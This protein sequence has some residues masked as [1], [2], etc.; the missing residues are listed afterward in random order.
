[1]KVAG[2]RGFLKEREKKIAN[3]PSKT[4][5]GIP[6]E[7]EAQQFSLLSISAL[8]LDYFEQVVTSSAS[9]HSPL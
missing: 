3:P 1:M 6:G 9:K 5:L 7:R 4:Q 8:D 2:S